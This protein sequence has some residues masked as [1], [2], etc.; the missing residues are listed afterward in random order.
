MLNGRRQSVSLPLLLLLLH[1]LKLSWGALLRHPILF[2]CHCR[3]IG[4]IYSSRIRLLFRLSLPVGLCVDTIL[5]TSR[6]VFPPS[7]ISL[8]SYE[9]SEYPRTYANLGM[10]YSPAI[11]CT[12]GNVVKFECLAS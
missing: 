10:S 5:V 4:R 8:S 3:R 9:Y 11:N 7:L 2:P 12:I 1:Q 6:C